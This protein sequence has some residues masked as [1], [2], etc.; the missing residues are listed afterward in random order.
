[1]N[2]F[3]SNIKYLR[4]NK[5]LTQSELAD[6]IGIN[7]P[8]I[9]SY[10]EGRAEPKLGVIQQISHFYKVNIDDLLEKD[11]SKEHSKEKDL[12]GSNLRVLP[13]IVDRSNT[14]QISLVPIKAAA[15]YLDGHSD[16]EY[17]EQLPNFNLPLK[18]LNSS[19]TYRM[20]QISGDSMLPIPSGAYIIGEYI[21]DWTLIKDNQPTI[22]VSTNEG[23]VFKRV[24]NK[25][26]INNTL[27]L[28]SDNQ[29]YKS[30]SIEL[31]E[32]MEIWKAVGYFSFDLSNHNAENENQLNQMNSVLMQLQQEVK[33]LKGN[34]N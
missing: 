21:L 20:F 27:E 19:G 15:G 30:Y 12:K 28:H 17:I 4:K 32:V 16:L 25:S 24:V 9:G 18:E 1:M 31:N 14:E 26:K 11:L 33:E 2:F 13:I 7:R 3:A 23:I 5:G 10:E 8:K 29:L 34:L 22:L 6:R